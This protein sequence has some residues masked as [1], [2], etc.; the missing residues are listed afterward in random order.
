MLKK[1]IPILLNYK[2]TI[3][4]KALNVRLHVLGVRQK[5][6]IVFIDIWHNNVY[7]KD[8]Y[9]SA[10]GGALCDLLE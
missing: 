3:S 4:C 6:N 8:V 5:R 10:F 2:K 7:Y 1:E 9:K